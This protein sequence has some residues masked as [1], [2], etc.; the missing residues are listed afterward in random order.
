MTG[1][2]IFS[3]ASIKRKPKSVRDNIS[4]P[5]SAAKL[6]YIE[7][8]AVDNASRSP[9]S[10]RGRQ[11]ERPMTTQQIV[12]S[13]N[14]CDANSQHSIS[15]SAS[16]ECLRKQSTRPDLAATSRTRSSPHRDLLK[17]EQSSST[18]RSHYDR[19]KL[20]LAVSQQTSDSSAR[21]FALRKGCP[22]VIPS[23]PPDVSCP[24]KPHFIPQATRQAA[25]EKRP[26]RLDFS[27]LFPKPLPRQDPLL[28]PQRYT[29]SPPP[30]SA[31]SEMPSIGVQSHFF[32][33]GKRV[34]A[35]QE[36]PALDPTRLLSRKTRKLE[37]K[38]ARTNM[39]KSR[40][41][42][43]NW[44][45][46][47]QG[48][49]SE[50]DDYDEPDMQPAFLETAF[51]TA[52]DRAPL[53]TAPQP[54]IGSSKIVCP[55]HGPDHHS[56]IDGKG[57]FSPKLE[58]PQGNQLGDALHEWQ[59]TKGKSSVVGQSLRSGSTLLDTA[60]LHEQ[61]VLCLSSSDDEDENVHKVNHRQI[62]EKR[63]PFL[64]DS[65]GID[66]IDSDVEIG[67]AQAVNTSFMRTHKPPMQSKNLRDISLVRTNS[68][69]QKPQAVE[70]PDRSSSRQAA[71]RYN[72]PT[73]PCTLDDG[74]PEAPFTGLGECQSVT[75]K[76]STKNA[77]RVMPG[78]STLMMALTPQE[79]SLLKAMRSKKA[80]M[81]YNTQIEVHQVKGD[82]DS[83]SSS[84][85]QPSGSHDWGSE[86]T[87]SI[88]ASLDANPL[89]FK[90]SCLPKLVWKEPNVPSGRVS[91]IFSE[92]LSSP[93]TG[94]DSPPTPTLDS[95]Q[96]LHDFHRLDQYN[97]PS[98]HTVKMNDLGP[99]RC[100]PESSQL[101]V[102]E[103]FQPSEKESVCPE[104]YPWM[105][106]QFNHRNNSPIIH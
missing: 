18:L 31:T 14:A 8:K 77:Q 5:S 80:S 54:M 7:T 52:S 58:P 53:D 42:V 60:D 67:T 37:Q 20:P 71:P 56:S 45:D 88:R 6:R 29:D 32:A 50:D 69:V 36:P 59:V 27:M 11:A 30:L 1:S 81:R 55:V 39:Q 19:K 75:S 24:P 13:I 22:P 28:S 15:T 4:D 25:A 76:W 12:A 96:V 100:R 97:D 66:S 23:L 105:I 49:I 9:Q 93:T 26:S 84:T 90:K 83:K 61:S 46:G 16:P 41:G 74:V 82:R 95:N 86:Y 99:T 70:I 43:Q 17:K 89:G 68:K 63:A 91:L 87:D 98:L 35:A 102:L 72:Y 103:N 10:A 21:D 34:N 40:G 106:S 94:R 78:Q 65:L 47:L 51:Q 73:V 92:S 3:F 101:I 38:F 79:A 104:E 85:Y 33:H 2:N 64:R 57:L 62:N 48:N 44:F